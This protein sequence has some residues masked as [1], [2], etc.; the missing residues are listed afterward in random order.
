MDILERW[1][2]S[3]LAAW[4]VDP[5][6][7]LR[8][9]EI[10]PPEARVGSP[11]LV[12]ASTVA[13]QKPTR[14]DDLMPG[15][16]LAVAA[17]KRFRLI[18]QESADTNLTPA[19]K[20]DLA[21]NNGLMVRGKISKVDPFYAWAVASEPLQS[22]LTR[23]GAGIGAQRLIDRIEAFA[24]RRRTIWS[25]PAILPAGTQLS[26]NMWIRA[27]YDGVGLSGGRDTTLIGFRQPAR[28]SRFNLLLWG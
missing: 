11:D 4:Y 15:L 3:F 14:R 12:V 10:T 13:G 19:A 17:A 26:P 16:T 5:L 22:V 7:A 23:T 18:K 2:A 1:L 24:G 8:V 9:T 6:G 20:E 28:G 27:T 21:A 25:Y